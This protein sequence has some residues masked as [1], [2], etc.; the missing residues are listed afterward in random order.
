MTKVE[1]LSRLKEE[2][3]SQYSYTELPD[4]FLQADKITILCSTHGPFE[5][6]AQSHLLGCGCPTCAREAKGG[7]EKTLSKLLEKHGG[8]IKLVSPFP[9]NQREQVTFECSTHGMFESTL[10]LNYDKNNI[11]KSEALFL[12]GIFYSI[13]TV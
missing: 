9:K 3:L 8:K 13:S 11:L 4:T 7:K 10:P 1:F 6:Q 2:Q 5:Q 12:K